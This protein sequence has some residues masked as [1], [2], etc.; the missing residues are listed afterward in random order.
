MAEHHAVQILCFVEAGQPRV[1][2]SPESKERFESAVQAGAAEHGREGLRVSWA[3]A[4]EAMVMAYVQEMNI[5]S[6]SLITGL[7]HQHP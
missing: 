3:Q 5:R 1:G 6:G 4:N 2:L 7:Y